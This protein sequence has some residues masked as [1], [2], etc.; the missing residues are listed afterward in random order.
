MSVLISLENGIKLLTL[1]LPESGSIWNNR[2]TCIDEIKG[3]C[4]ERRCESE[5]IC[6]LYVRDLEVDGKPITNSRS[7]WKMGVS[8]KWDPDNPDTEKVYVS[9]K[10][11]AWDR[12]ENM[13]KILDELGIEIILM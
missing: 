2:S 3:A 6:E 13:K 12:G 1:L 9:I 8:T 5:L 10:D 4:E 11:Y 7:D